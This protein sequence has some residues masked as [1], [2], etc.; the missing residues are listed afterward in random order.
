[1]ATQRNTS[2][3]PLKLL[4][5]AAKNDWHQV[6]GRSRFPVRRRP[7]AWWCPPL[8]ALK[9][10][11]RHTLR[12][13]M[14]RHA[15][16]VIN[17]ESYGFSPKGCRNS[18]ESIS[19][20]FAFLPSLVLLA[21]AAGLLRMS[22]LADLAGAC[23]QRPRIRPRLFGQSKLGESRF[24]GARGFARWNSISPPPDALAHACRTARPAD[25]QIPQSEIS[26]P[27]RASTST[28]LGLSR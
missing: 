22:F 7:L 13:P 19:T 3:L 1:M 18:R 5:P 10:R 26:S 11:K 23:C 15:R 16:S 17:T 27:G 4:W 21:A 25:K 2:H 6:V 20:F 28:R 24:A 14:W 12:R 9:K 8:T